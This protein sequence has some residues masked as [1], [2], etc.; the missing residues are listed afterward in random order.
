M[1]HTGVIALATVTVRRNHGGSTCGQRGV[2]LI[3]SSVAYAGNAQDHLTGE[4][5]LQA[6]DGAGQTWV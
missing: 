5:F 6:F 1:D 3:S 4:T 2:P